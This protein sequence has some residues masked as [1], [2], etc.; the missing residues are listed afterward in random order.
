MGLIE[1]AIWFLPWLTES[2]LWEKSIHLAIGL[3]LIFIK[4]REWCVDYDTA[5]G[6][7]GVFYC[8]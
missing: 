6:Y 5:T 4:P 7:D 2:W 3:S 1:G 8:L